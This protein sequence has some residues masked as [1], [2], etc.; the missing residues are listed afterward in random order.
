MN[1][2]VRVDGHGNDGGKWE[3]TCWGCN[4]QLTLPCFAPIFKCGYCG[5]ITSDKSSAT[6][7]RL[8]ISPRCN[9][10]LDHFMVAFVLLFVLFIVCKLS[11][12][13]LFLLLPF[14]SSSSSSGVCLIERKM[15]CSIEVQGIKLQSFKASIIWDIT[16]L[17]MW[18]SVALKFYSLSLAPINH[19]EKFP[20]FCG[21]VCY[22]A[23]YFL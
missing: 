6:K 17:H 10:L 2:Q 16:T 13:S 4:L 12:L 9:S 20:F 1:A 11:Y 3:A 15:G 5:A 23:F 8:R 14:L 22:L 21:W 19:P 18:F 7:P